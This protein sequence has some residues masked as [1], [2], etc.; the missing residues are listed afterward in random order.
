[1]IVANHIGEG[2]IPTVLAGGAG[3]GSVLLAI[4]RVR[5]GQLFDRLRRR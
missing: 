1:M 5:L 2:L 4:G 3:A